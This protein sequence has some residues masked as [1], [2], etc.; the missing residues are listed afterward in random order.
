MSEQPALRFALNHMVAPGL[1]PEAFLALARD[2]GC[3]A[4]E[5]R[6]DLAGN[7]LADG[8]PAAKVGAAAARAGIAIL[9]INALQRFNDWSADRAA[10]AED[11][12]RA[13]ADCGAAALILVPVN[14]GSGRDPVEARDNL[15]RALTGLA[16]ILERHGIQGY[17]EPLGFAVCSLR[18]KSAAAAA[19]RD[20]GLAA[21][22][23]ITHDTFH[24]HLA[25]ET[26]I[27]PDLTAL[28]HVSGVDNPSVA[29]DDMRDSH[30]ILVTAQ[31]RL[32]N[33]GQIARLRAAGVA[34][35]LSFE[36]FAEAVHRAADIRADLARSI[37]FIRAG[38]ARRAA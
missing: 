21:R 23:R 22:F 28:V 13:C 32:D 19:I 31:D 34:A 24:H 3:D 26:E 18:F 11:L 12:A 14:D 8:T 15:T 33:L 36:P 35:H 37:E 2:L 9:T 6:N 16:P 7:A 17:V 30:R 38:L 27:F 5:M 1:P 4:V 10:E 20:L 29:V 25:G